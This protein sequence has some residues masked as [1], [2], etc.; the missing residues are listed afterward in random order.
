MRSCGSQKFQIPRTGNDS[1]LKA[2]GTERGPGLDKCL[3]LTGY[4]VSDEDH[5]SYI[6][7]YEVRLKSTSV[8]P[9]KAP[10]S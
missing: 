9:R 2:Y 1:Q 3:L 8:L 4:S 5:K 6:A 7:A 10:Q